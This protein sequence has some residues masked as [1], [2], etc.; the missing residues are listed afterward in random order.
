MIGP[1]KYRK[2]LFDL[3]IEGMKIN[4]STIDDAMDTLNELNEIENVLKKNQI[5]CSCGY[6]KNQTGSYG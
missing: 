5:Q 4:V 6:T 1:K 2:Q 3:G